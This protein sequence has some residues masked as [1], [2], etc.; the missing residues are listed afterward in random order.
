MFSFGKVNFPPII[1]RS[2]FKHYSIISDIK[3]K[4][5]VSADPEYFPFKE[6]IELIKFFHNISYV[7]Y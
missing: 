4:C 5:Q 2:E 7:L 3:V 6:G 1:G